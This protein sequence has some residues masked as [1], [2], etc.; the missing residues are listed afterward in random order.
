MNARYVTILFAFTMLIGKP[1]FGQP[2][3]TEDFISDLIGSSIAI[4]S[5]I[6]EPSPEIN[7]VIN[8]SGAN[9]TWDF[10]SFTPTDTFVV[11]QDLLLL[12][13][14]EAI[15]QEL[16]PGAEFA[17]DIE[18]DTFGMELEESSFLEYYALEQGDWIEF[19]NVTVF[20]VDE[21]GIMDVFPVTN[22]PPSLLYSFPITFGKTWEDSTEITSDFGSIVFRSIQEVDTEID[23]W[24]TLI[25][26]FGTVQ[27]LRINSLSYDVSRSSGERT[28][29]D[30]SVEFL[31]RERIIVSASIDPDGTLT[32]VE[33]GRIDDP[34]DT[35]NEREGLV[36][37]TFQLSQN[38]PNPFNPITTIRY[39]LPKAG[40]VTLT[41]YSLTGQVIQQL[42]NGT[43]SAG[44]HD[45]T[46]DASNVASGLYLY[47]LETEE[48]TVTRLM[49]L[50]K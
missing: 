30:T 37:D 49:T 23:G 45:V 28:F 19:G 4:T 11:T 25:T 42:V 40:S 50:I 2:T 34:T 27:A 10:S 13:S 15:G 36:P 44:Q 5:Y 21:D 17:L 24:G 35:S 22:S 41:V 1:A 14:E 38:Y 31:S 3:I 47:R 16:F 8:L 26:P 20:D 32:D 29:E 7:A 43:K 6:M 18:A 12:P 48:S 9:Q 39:S 46:F 33:I